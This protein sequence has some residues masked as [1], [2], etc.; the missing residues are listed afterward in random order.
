MVRRKAGVRVWGL[1]PEMLPWLL[2]PA[3]FLLGGLCGHLM[4]GLSGERLTALLEG[5]GASLTGVGTADLGALARRCAGPV[6]L[7]LVLS[8]SA[9]GTVGLPVLLAGHGFVTGYLISGLVRTW[10]LE[11]WYAAALWLG[12]EEL[13]LL[14]VL[15]AISAPGWNR[16]RELMMQLKTNRRQTG[17]GRWLFCLIGLLILALYECVIWRF[18]FP[19]LSAGQ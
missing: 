12:V 7:A 19:A 15:L 17:G 9:W 2:L 14:T 6:L 1:Y 5:Y 8:A 10:G 13:L 16:A 11:G 3:A 18:L 4:A